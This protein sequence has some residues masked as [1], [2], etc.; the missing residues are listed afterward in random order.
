MREATLKR[1]H[2][3]VSAYKALLEE[4]GGRPS[5]AE[6]DGVLAYIERYGARRKAEEKQAA[7]LLEKPPASRLADIESASQ[8]G[9]F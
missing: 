1:H 8:G 4:Q 7:A 2:L 9:L 5:Q 6:T 3:S